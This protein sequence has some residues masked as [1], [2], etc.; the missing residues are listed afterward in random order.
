MQGDLFY[1]A[2][3][4]MSS[5]GKS[6]SERPAFRHGLEDCRVARFDIMVTIE[7]VLDVIT[8]SVKIG[9]V[10]IRQFDCTAAPDIVMVP[11]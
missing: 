4:T 6:E 7:S 9:F 1:L 10:L 3:P 5:S 2:L 11:V 8:L